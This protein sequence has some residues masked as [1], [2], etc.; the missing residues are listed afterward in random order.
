MYGKLTTRY[1]LKK[2]FNSSIKNSNAILAL[3]NELENLAKVIY[4]MTNT[5]KNLTKMVLEHNETITQFKA[6]NEAMIKQAQ[7]GN[8][9]MFGFP[10]LNSKEEKPN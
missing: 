2:M 1:A 10:S 6:I 8:V 3:A 5:I 7:Q 4:A 9:D